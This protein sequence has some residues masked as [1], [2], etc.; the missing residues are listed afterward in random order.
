MIAF[1]CSTCRRA[2][3]VPDH[4]AGKRAKCGCGQLL[5]VPAENVPVTVPPAAPSI[6]LRGRRLASDEQ[7]M[8]KL[9]GKAD[10]P[11]RLVEVVGTPPEQYVVEF[12]IASLRDA[13]TLLTVHR[14]EINL[15][16]E[17]PRI[18]P[19][20]RMLTPIFHPNID[21]ASICIGDHWAAGE[22]IGDLVIRIGEMLAYQAYNIRSP[23]N[24]E[25]AMWADLNADKLPTDGRDLRSLIQV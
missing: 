11:I 19:Q 24:A 13:K 5:I 25:A 2:F 21:A 22:R 15:T 1:Q 6:G 4:Y 9:F 20:C 14:A 23:L 18:G 7:Q 10:G 12:H 17:Y 3:N 16:S 8:R